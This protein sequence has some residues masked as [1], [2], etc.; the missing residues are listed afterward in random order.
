MDADLLKSDDI[1][2][3]LD[4]DLTNCLMA[5]RTSLACKLVKKPPKEMYINL[6]KANKNE[7]GYRV[8]RG[9]WAFE[10]NEKLTVKNLISC[11]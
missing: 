10:S 4:L 1:L 7:K 9:W 2:G 3:K 11:L 8:E 5:S 6:F